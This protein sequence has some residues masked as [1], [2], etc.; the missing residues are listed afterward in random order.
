MQ[1][2][3]ISVVIPTYNREYCIRRS[4]ES[5]LKQTY[6]VY[7]VVIVDDG[8]TDN[9]LE[10]VKEIA[11]NRINYYKTDGNK[12]AGA[13][14]NFGV[15]MAQGE[16]IVFH[17]SDDICFENRVEQEMQCLEKGDNLGLVYGAHLVQTSE[18][19]G[20]IEPDYNQSEG[21][22]GELF[23]FLLMRNTI[24]APTI[25]MKKE[26]FEAV[27]GFD[28]NMSSLEDWD[29]AIRVSKSYKIGFVS[30]T[31][32]LTEYQENGLSADSFKYYQNRCYMLRKYLKDYMALGLIN[33]VLKNILE[34]AQNSGM[35]SQVERLLEIYLGT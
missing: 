2:K 31:L 23:S 3:K 12:G 17:D 14:R 20:Y 5:V 21:I 15:K 13:A 35:L 26:I 22:E 19:E 7:E 32:I 8:S 11:D 16:Y 30:D 34:K 10:V 24:D 6:P 9:T 29:F 33:D 1:N 28:E 25:L 27:G 18:T 4:I